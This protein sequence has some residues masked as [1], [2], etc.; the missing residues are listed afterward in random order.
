MSFPLPWFVRAKVKTRAKLR[1]PMP[2]DLVPANAATDLTAPL[3]KKAIRALVPALVPSLQGT[4]SLSLTILPTSLRVI[5]FFLR[6]EPPGLVFS[7]TYLRGKL[8]PS[9]FPSTGSGPRLPPQIS[10]ENDV[11]LPPV[12]S[13]KPHDPRVGD[14][15]C[16]QYMTRPNYW[17]ELGQWPSPIRGTPQR[18]SR[19]A[20]TGF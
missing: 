14:I 6:S 8:A 7:V 5:R 15:E 3:T 4:Y 17:A 16:K 12:T 19:Q 1:V 18:L 20:R 13:E 10:H 2:V 9:A 11:G